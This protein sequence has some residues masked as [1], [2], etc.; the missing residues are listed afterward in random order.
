M[1][2]LVVNL[3]IVGAIL[4]ALGVFHLALPWVLAWPHESSEASRLN[5]EVNYVHCYFIGLACLLWGLLPLAAGQS[6]LD[7]NPVTRLVLV[8]AVV[9]WASR[10]VIQVFV[11]NR[12]ARES[13][14]WRA[15]S[16]LG[17]GLWIY[18]TVV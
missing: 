3:R 16:C 4:M 8:G 13:R 7:R 18:L 15:L 6:L 5:R 9:F 1:S 10:L 11:F 12:H 2:N 14:D 17:T